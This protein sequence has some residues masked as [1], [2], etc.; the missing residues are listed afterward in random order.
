MKRVYLMKGM[1]A[2]AMGLVVVSCNKT[3]FDQNAYQQA[4]VQESKESFLN[5]VMAG[6]EIDPNQTWST[7][8]PMDVSVTASKTGVLKVYTANPIGNRTASLYTVNVTKGQNVAFTVACPSNLTNLYVAVMNE[9]GQIIDMTTIDAKAEKAEVDMNM[10][11]ENTR[12][13]VSRRAATA[14]AQPTFSGRPT[15]PTI[16]KNTLAEAQAAGA[17]NA[18][19]G[20]ANNGTYYIEGA[21]YTNVWGIDVQNTPLTMYFDGNVHFGGNNY[22]NGGTAFC[23]TTGSTLKLESIRNGLVIYL[24]PNATL[25]LTNIEWAKLQNSNS[26]IYMNAGSRILA[27]KLCLVNGVTILNAGGT[28]SCSDYLELDNQT[29]LY[30]E[31]TVECTNTNT[32]SNCGI[33]IHNTDAELVNRGTVTSKSTLILAGGGH[34][35]NDEPGITN[36]TGLTE[37]QNESDK[38]MN[39]GVYTS[40]TFKCT[41]TQK[42]YNNC[43]LTVTGKFTM[44]GSASN[45]VLNGDASVICDSFEWNSDNYFFLGSNSILSVA[46]ELK[47]NNGNW[48]YGFYQSGDNYS[49]ISAKSITT[50][51]PNSQWRA[52]YSGKIYVDT[53]SHFDFVA[54]NQTQKNIYYTDDVVFTKK[55]GTASVGWKESKCKP[56]YGTPDNGDDGG[57]DGGDDD[58]IMY[59]YYAF[60]DLGAIGDFDFNDVVLRLS[61]PENGISTV[62][63]CAAGGTL[64]VQVVYNDANVG[65]EV[66]T[67]FGVDV[68][69]MVNTGYETKAFVTLGTVTI[70]AD[71]DMANLPFGIVVTGN[72]GSSVKVTREVEHT[73]TAPLMIVVSGYDTGDDAGKWFWAR[74]RVNISIAYPQFGA[75]GANVQS[76]TNWYWNYTDDKVWKY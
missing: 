45:F 63:L 13:V 56:A 9:K 73:G 11:T 55:Q 35:Y 69:T 74:E 33:Y 16:Y 57:D 59:Y 27:K 42:V 37:I 28:I 10:P 32:G 30:N 62:Q 66:H 23:V 50:D 15:M 72:D 29:L 20:I 24:A 61:A 3:D 54:M 52:W 14:P 6:Q 34:F 49:V 58:P 75:W 31:G 7:T 5:N 19:N 4:K 22:Q 21:S 65:R 2:L 76:N 18:K 12:A 68:S 64:P 25:D 26:A 67:E 8:N 70:A 1:A 46:N 48:E 36:V 47:S 39:D 38:W 41:D 53:D 43:R 51:Y 60:E 17:L 71:A 40:G 44:A